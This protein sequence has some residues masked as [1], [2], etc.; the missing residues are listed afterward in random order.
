M[1]KGVELPEHSLVVRETIGL[2]NVD[3]LMCDSDYSPRVSSNRRPMCAAV[4][5]LSCSAP[6]QLSLINPRGRHVLYCMLAHKYSTMRTC[7]ISQM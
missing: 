1:F 7:A 2:A 3:T 6:S 5:F 4:L